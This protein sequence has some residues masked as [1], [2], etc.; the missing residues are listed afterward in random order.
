MEG[1]AA[2][3]AWLPRA[4]FE[5]GL[6]RLRSLMRGGWSAA[7]GAFVTLR[8][9]LAL[10]DPA[11]AAIDLA[12]RIEAAFAWLRRVLRLVLPKRS[13]RLSAALAWRGLAALIG[14][15]AAAA[16]VTGLSAK[17][18]ATALASLTT[19]DATA[20]PFPAAAAPRDRSSISGDDG[21]WVA[22]SRPVPLFGLAAPELP[23]ELTA[24]EARRSRDGT[25]R[26]DTL[27]FGE[28]GGEE[29]Y[30]L[31]RLRSGIRRDDLS[32][33][34]LISLVREAAGQ[35]LAIRRSSTP[36]PLRTR[37]G[38]VASADALL[39]DGS[40]ERSCLA[41]RMEAGEMPFA[42]SGWWCAARKPTD[43]QQLTCLLE[44]LDLV[45]AGDDR[46]LRAAFSRTELER[47]P[48]CAPPRLSATGRKVSWLDSDGTAPAL[49]VKPVPETAEAVKPTRERKRKTRETQRVTTARA[50]TASAR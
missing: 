15:G 29:P 6:A 9:R 46:E 14:I 18:D 43:R 36:A 35:A 2:M 23:R 16:L 40:A 12:D 11:A 4:Q 42:L 22:L 19:S 34:F 10:L 1:G 8:G 30:L 7:L 13:A 21:A 37:F 31:L 5:T 38:Q 45:N 28:F 49:R 24:Y 48:G 27:R 32:Q 41:F 25:R 47:Q 50:K 17:G 39:S 26:E 3:P 33:P 44:R 20:R